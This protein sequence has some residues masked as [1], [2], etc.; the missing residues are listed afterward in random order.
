MTDKNNKTEGQDVVAPN[1]WIADLLPPDVLTTDA[2]AWRAPL[3]SEIRVLIGRDSMTGMAGAAAA[4]LIG[5]T[6]QTWRK[7]TAGEA[8]KVR[9][10][11]PFASWQLLLHCTGVQLVLVHA[12]VLK[13]PM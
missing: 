9:H 13:K 1:A 7:Y 4:K 6:P 5:V 11:I 12:P 2:A 8:A 3:G 10:L